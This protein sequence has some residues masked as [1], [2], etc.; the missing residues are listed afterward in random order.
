M[1]RILCKLGREECMLREFK[2]IRPTNLTRILEI[3]PIFS[4]FSSIFSDKIKNSSDK[5]LN[6]VHW[7][8]TNNVLFH[9]NYTLFLLKKAQITRK[10]AQYLKRGLKISI[11][12][13]SENRIIPSNFFWTRIWML[14]GEIEVVKISQIDYWILN[15]FIWLLSRCLVMSL[16]T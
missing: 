6:N 5:I 3:F 2:I 4:D 11:F 15:I 12:K 16:K 10:R 8:R 13:P 1:V 9:Q 14:N 7:N